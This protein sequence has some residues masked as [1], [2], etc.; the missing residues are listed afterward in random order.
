MN[1]IKVIQ[2]IFETV[3]FDV[4]DINGDGFI[5]KEEISQLLKKAIIRNRSDDDPDE[6]F[7]ELVELAIKKLVLIFI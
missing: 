5:S 6:T 1:M 4:Y 2:I 7:K 3:C